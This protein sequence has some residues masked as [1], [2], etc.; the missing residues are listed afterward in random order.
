MKPPP[1]FKYFYRCEK[2]NKPAIYMSHE[3]GNENNTTWHPITGIINNNNK[4]KFNFK[5]TC[6]T[7]GEFPFVWG[8]TPDRVWKIPDG[9]EEVGT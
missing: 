7:C 5:M 4:H 2:C 8:P 1:Q 3:Y 6:A 9:D